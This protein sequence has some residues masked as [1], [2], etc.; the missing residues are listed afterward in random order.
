MIT[1]NISSSATS[2]P[3]IYVQKQDAK[4]IKTYLEDNSFLDKRYRMVPVSSAVGNYEVV[5][6]DSDV[7]D[8]IAIPVLDNYIDVMMIMISSA[9]KDDACKEFIQKV[10]NY[11]RCICP[12]STSMLGNN[13]TKNKS[14]VTEPSSAESS[15]RLLTNVQYALVETLST[16]AQHVGDD[17]VNA[18]SCDDN[19]K[20][21]IEQMV[22]RLS[23]KTCPK[24]LEVI[25]DDKTL[26]IPRHALCVQK[27][28]DDSSSDEFRNLLLTSAKMVHE[29]SNQ[30]LGK[31][32]S[33]SNTEDDKTIISNIQSRLWKNLANI[34]NTTRIVRRGD[35]DPE[36]GVRESG[37]RILYPIPNDILLSCDNNDHE[38]VYNRGYAPK[39]IGPN[40]AG[41]ITVT[42]H[43]IRQSF[44]LTRVMFS[45]GNVTE[46]KRFGMSLV[47]PNET[48]LDMYAGIGYYSLPALI[49]GKAKHVT[50]CEWNVNALFALRHNIKSNGIEE[51]RV[52]ILEG[53][54]RVSLK[55]LLLE[56]ASDEDTAITQFD[57][58]SLGLLPSSEGGWAIS[59]ACLNQSA[60][61]WLHVHAN[62]PT[63]ERKSWTHWL[64]RSL[65]NLANAPSD[66]QRL[67]LEWIAVCVNVEKVKSFAPKVDHVVA[68]VFV[69]PQGSPKVP[70]FIDEDE[71][72]KKCSETGALDPFRKFIITS[73]HTPPPSCALNEEG[74]LHQNW[75]R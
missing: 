18:T 3:V 58:I 39:E 61:G 40:S 36:S 26:V 69:G 70:S 54:C 46:K 37:H 16:T 65:A 27:R 60:G 14:N 32:G 2:I 44:D 43:T 31:D 49:H 64:C 41:W 4:Y 50:T 13:K 51:D 56:E 9:E 17:A 12:Y 6:Y 19:T 63:V 59:I 28:R 48:I 30:V 5:H 7:K 42:E 62:V 29:K 72:E 8:C 1:P 25:G 68:D 21:N 35:I 34:Y 47:Q 33:A 22:R 75:M 67:R 45:R 20:T 73:Q 23:N 10:M 53:D 71:L 55:R 52:T 74:I 57:R 66:E 11:G 15:P 24:K 38:D